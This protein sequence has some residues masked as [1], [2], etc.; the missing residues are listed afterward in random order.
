MLDLKGYGWL[1]WEGVQL[2]VMVSVVSMAGAVI[3]GL[4]AALAKLGRSR[5]RSAIVEAYTTVV[6]GVPELVLLLLVYYGVPTLVQDVA[7]S[8][9]YDFVVAIN[10]FAAGIATITFIYGAFACEVF[11]GAYLNVPAGQHEA[12]AVL[13]LN[14]MA[15]LRLVILPQVFR[16]ALPGLGNVWMVLV[17]ATALISI[18]QLPELMR[19]ADVAARAT[20]MPFT[21]FFAACLVYLTITLAS[22]WAQARAEGWAGRGVVGGRL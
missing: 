20:R 9:G 22:M 4:L 11:R 16:Y 14:R 15:A 6:R 1:L 21:F 8:L 7:A 2:T 19:N 12:A 13:G 18:I 3:V 5:L 10:P 17:K